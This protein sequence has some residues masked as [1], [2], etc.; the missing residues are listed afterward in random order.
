MNADEQCYEGPTQAQYDA[1]AARLAEARSLLGRA[2]N[3]SA[4]V[5]PDFMAEIQLWLRTSDSA[6]EGAK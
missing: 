5:H 2:M 4:R 1:L 6:N 3:H